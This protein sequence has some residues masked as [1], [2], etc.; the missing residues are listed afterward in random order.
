[1]DEAIRYL[2][3]WLLKHNID[4]HMVRIELK[5]E[6][7]RDRHQASEALR[8]EW[9]PTMLPQPIPLSPHEARISGVH[10]VFGVKDA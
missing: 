3:H 5:F 1:M 10:V 6:N 8:S 4:P 7:D 9:L 2:S